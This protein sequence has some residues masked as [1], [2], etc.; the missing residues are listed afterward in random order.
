M[1]LDGRAMALELVEANPSNGE[2]FLLFGLFRAVAWRI[3][4][5]LARPRSA[6]AAHHCVVE[7]GEHVVRLAQA[8]PPRSTSTSQVPEGRPWTSNMRTS[9]CA[10]SPLSASASRFCW[11]DVDHGADPPAATARVVAGLRGRSQATR[12]VL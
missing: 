5:R 8:L 1:G 7:A 10:S 6:G 4:A 9:F 3:V 2:I 11:G 12:G